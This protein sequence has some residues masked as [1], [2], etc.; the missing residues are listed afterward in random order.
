[1]HA[2]KLSFFVVSPEEPVQRYLG[3]EEGEE[4]GEEA[5]AEVVEPG[6]VDDEGRG[7]DEGCDD[8]EERDS[9]HE[10]LEG[11]PDDA[12]WPATYLRFID[13]RGQLH[14]SCLPAAFSVEEPFFLSAPLSPDSPFLAG[15]SLFAPLL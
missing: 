8:E 7:D 9:E 14:Q 12:V 3:A 10:R 2:Y 11:A 5:V 1:M 15:A 6:G 13:A 4:E